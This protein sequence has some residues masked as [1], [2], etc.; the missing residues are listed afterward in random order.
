MMGVSQGLIGWWMVK[1]GLIDSPDVSH[2]RLAV[3]LITAFLTCA[4][5]LWIA[6]PLL[7]PSSR[8]GNKVIFNH[9]NLN[10]YIR[11]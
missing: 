11:P 2:F 5:T 8:E 1:S 10:G 7:F 3:H 9:F 6:L 4:Y